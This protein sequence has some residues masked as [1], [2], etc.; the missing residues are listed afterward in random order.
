LFLEIFLDCQLCQVSVL[1]Q[2][3]EDHLSYHYQ[4]SDVSVGTLVS[5]IYTL[6]VG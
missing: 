3:F 1:N 2:H 4:G 6:V 5:C